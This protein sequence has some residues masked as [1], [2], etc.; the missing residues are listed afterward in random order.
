MYID[1]SGKYSIY[2]YHNKVKEYYPLRNIVNSQINFWNCNINFWTPNLRIKGLKFRITLRNLRP[3]R[4]VHD[5]LDMSSTIMFKSSFENNLGE[6]I[7]KT[8]IKR[9]DQITS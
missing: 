7:K 6:T 2:E 3:W 4:K 5:F 1:W 8:I 9:R